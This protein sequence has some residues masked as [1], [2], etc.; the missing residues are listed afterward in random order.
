VVS[1]EGI[2]PAIK[3]KLN[4]I[5]AH[6]WHKK[7]CKD[8][9]I[10]LTDREVI[11][12]RTDRTMDRRGKEWIKLAHA[13]TNALKS[14]HHYLQVDIH[15]SRNPSYLKTPPELPGGID[16]P[17]KCSLLHLSDIHFLKDFSG[18]SKFD[19]DAAVRKAI[20]E[21]AKWC[22]EHVGPIH[23]V[24]V[25]GDIAYA[26]QAEEYK[27][28]VGWLAQLCQQLGC[29]DGHVW[30]V[31]G[32][33]DIDRS[34]LKEFSVIPVLHEQ[35]R[36][37]GAKLDEHLRKHLE[38][39]NTGP[40][41]FAPLRAYNEI[42]GQRFN[43]FTKPK[44]PWWEDELELNDGSKLRIRGLNSALISG[45]DDD[46][47]TKKLI[48]GAAQT[49]YGREPGVEY[50][51][52]CHHPTDWLLDS[53]NTQEALLAYS[54][55]QLFGHKHIQQVHQMNNTLW[56]TA[57]A[58]HPS[59]AEQKWLPR[60]N[61]LSIWIDGAGADR[62]LCVDVYARTWLQTE[63]LFTAEQN[64]NGADHK[65]YRLK[66]SDW[67][68]AMSTAKSNDSGTNGEKEDSA[69]PSQTSLTLGRKKLLYKF[70]GLPHHTRMA[71]MKQFD[72]LEGDDV[73][74]P[75]SEVFSACF[76]RARTKGVLDNVWAA[77]EAE[78]D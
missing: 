5:E 59:R 21:D 74:K 16:L 15:T 30:C 64:S 57:G 49:E 43:S 47:M 38:N 52:L 25:T 8:V 54:R 40:V 3:R 55:I 37:S 42:I 12:E 36:S 48:L 29:D 76:E 33:H 39:D 60:Y 50:L 66:L 20:L 11:A 10:S 70:A 24:L 75:D 51:T 61:C 32:N 27:T 14:L 77:I 65:T 9:V 78:L 67:K 13:P 56:L 23:G 18:V 46:N 63:R 34:A 35:L 7:H 17:E 26:G 44:Q 58:V 71:I 4:N 41:L 1:A 31:P 53:E 6:G 2:E 62:H 22:R 68:Q 45:P 69:K 19:Q 73:T 72:L 28:A